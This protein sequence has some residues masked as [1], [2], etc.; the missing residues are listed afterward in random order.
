MIHP[1]Y[2]MPCTKEKREKA[3]DVSLIN[4]ASR[5]VSFRSKCCDPCSKPL[6]PHKR[7]KKKRKAN[8]LHVDP[9]IH[10][11][12]E[13]EERKRKV[14]VRAAGDEGRDREDGSGE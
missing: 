7:K 8:E 14:A 4:E 10:A 11:D 2:P 5:G 13:S 1:C 3:R 6:R 9:I 12:V